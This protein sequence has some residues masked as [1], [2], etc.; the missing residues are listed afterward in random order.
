MPFVSKAYSMILRVE[1][2]KDIA[3]P[4]LTDHSAHYV[5]S[6]GNGSAYKPSSRGQNG[7]GYSITNKKGLRYYDYCKKDNHNRDACF[8]LHGEPDWYKEKMKDKRK[9]SQGSFAGNVT[10]EYAETP[11]DKMDYG[12]NKENH[13]WV[14]QMDMAGMIK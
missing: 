2:Q 11:F 8:K 10:G 7:R 13:N 14:N 12:E 6:G 1:K 3:L 9:A 5:R 4:N